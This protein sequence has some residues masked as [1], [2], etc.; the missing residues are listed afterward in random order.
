MENKD[1]T[2]YSTKCSQIFNSIFQIMPKFNK[3]NNNT[4]KDYQDLADQMK[5]LELL[6]D[7]CY[8]DVEETVTNI[9][10]IKKETLNRNNSPRNR[11]DTESSYSNS[12]FSFNDCDTERELI[13][14]LRKK[15]KN[16][17][18]TV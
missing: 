5:D 15:L 3:D 2:Q 8:V 11:I 13:E 14:D 18:L 4:E 9:S 16:T 1:F 7:Q 17:K 12:S 6:L 10:R